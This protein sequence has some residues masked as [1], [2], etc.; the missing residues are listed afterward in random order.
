[1][2]PH[3]LRIFMTAAEARI[4]SERNAFIR[5]Q[6]RQA[7]EERSRQEIEEQKRVC[8]AAWRSEMISN[9]KKAIA[10]SVK[11]GHFKTEQ[12]LHTSSDPKHPLYINFLGASENGSALRECMNLW[13][14]EHF[15]VSVVGRCV[16]HD[17]SSAYL[18]SGGE[19][20]SMTPYYTYDT[21]LVIEW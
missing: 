12:T 15:R 10:Y 19:C 14:S 2:P 8:I 17:E 21:V 3:F 16:S 4:L 9:M 13:E 1:M 20:G 7:K 18:N 5:E 11:Y 6:E